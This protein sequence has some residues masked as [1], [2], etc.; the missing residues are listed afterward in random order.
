MTDRYAVIGNPIKHSQSPFIHTE[1]ARQTQQQ[2]VYTAELVELGQVKQFVSEFRNHNGKGLNVT[3]P[4]KLDAFE[5][6]E[7]LSER[8]QRAGA[9]NTLMLDKKITGDTTDGTGL[10][11]DLMLN[12]NIPLKN[13]RILI[14][15][16]GG[17][18]RGVIESIL[19]HQPAQIIIANRTVEKAMTLKNIFSDLG[20][21]DGCGFDD[22]NNE[23]FDLIINGTSASLSGDLPPIPNDLL[24]SDA[25]V[26]D[27]MYSAKPTPFMQWGE[28][29][30]AAACFDGLGM[31]VEQ[32]AES[33]YIWRGVK[34]ETQAVINKLREILS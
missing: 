22:L 6:A 7:S 23:Q 15:G 25:A 30:K 18:V 19:N 17:A 12:H 11:N 31:L 29:Q 33:F 26:Y 3:V 8:A 13:K 27:M 9:V 32:A 21:I 10:V 2:L 24:N 1:F 34:P 5:L 16:A 20:S 28:Q 14:L 4:F